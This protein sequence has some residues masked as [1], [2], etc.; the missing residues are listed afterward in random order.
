MVF[1]NLN[2]NVTIC[3]SSEQAAFENAVKEGIANTAIVDV[4]YV[5]I[6]NNCTELSLRRGQSLSTAVEVKFK[7]TVPAEFVSASMTTEAVLGSLNNS[8]GTLAGLIETNYNDYKLSAA[9]GDLEALV[10]GG[11]ELAVT[12]SSFVD[13]NAEPAR[14]TL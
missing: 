6:I 9:D 1:E 11:G 12:S 2:E 8:T 3:G 4:A 13:D 10:V 5:D 14:G 7:I